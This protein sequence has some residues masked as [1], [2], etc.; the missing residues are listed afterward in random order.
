MRDFGEARIFHE[1]AIPSVI[2]NT[3]KSKEDYQ[4]HNFLAIWDNFGRFNNK[5]YFL[6]SFKSTAKADRKIN[7]EKHWSNSFKNIVVH[8][9]KLS[10]EKYKDW[11]LEIT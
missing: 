2:H 6:N 1:L 9:I 5:D 4:P 10:N 7:F 11:L 3:I 8:P